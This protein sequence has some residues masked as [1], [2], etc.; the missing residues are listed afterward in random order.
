MISGIL[1]TERVPLLALLAADGW[2]L[3]SEL[4]EGEWWSS[5]IARQ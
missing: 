3:E 2:T 5:V 1:V 4:R